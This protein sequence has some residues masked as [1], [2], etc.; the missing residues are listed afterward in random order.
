M[1]A[2]INSDEDGKGVAAEKCFG[3]GKAHGEDEHC[4]NDDAIYFDEDAEVLERGFN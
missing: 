2:E 4:E 3:C 1:K